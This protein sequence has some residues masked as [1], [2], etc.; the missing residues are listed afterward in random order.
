MDLILVN[1]DKKY[2][3]SMQFLDVPTLICVFLHQTTGAA[4]VFEPPFP[5]LVMSQ[6]ECLLD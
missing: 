1:R 4:F 6:L 3:Q 5:Q 2:N